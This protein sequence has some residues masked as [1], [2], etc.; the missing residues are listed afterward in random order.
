MIRTDDDN[1]H[2]ADGGG[3]GDELLLDMRGCRWSDTATAIIVRSSLMRRLDKAIT[4]AV[5]R[6]KWC[7]L[8]H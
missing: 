7:I 1:D 5:R 8:S 6:L 2:R 4:I 3:V